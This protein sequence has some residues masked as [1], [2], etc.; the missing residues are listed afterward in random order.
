MLIKRAKLRNNNNLVDI[1]IENGYIKRIENHIDSHYPNIDLQGQLVVHNFIDIHTHLREPGF[2]YK[3]TID[4]GSLA[5]LYGGYGTIVAM[6]RDNGFEVDVVEKVVQKK[7][8]KNAK[9]KAER[10]SKK[11]ESEKKTA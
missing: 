8:E 5:A 4:T 9:A 2:E 6:A 7:R 3:E 11:E 10:L 1:L